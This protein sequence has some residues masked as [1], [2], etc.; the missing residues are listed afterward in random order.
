MALGQPNNKNMDKMTPEQAAVWKD[1]YLDWPGAIPK[2]E[3]RRLF[4][5][6]KALREQLAEVE[7]DRDSWKATAEEASEK[8]VNKVLT[9]RHEMREKSLQE[10]LDHRTISLDQAQAMLAE[11]QQ[12]IANL[13]RQRSDTCTSE[14]ALHE[15]KG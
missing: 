7:R 5:S 11:A 12:K 10:Q 2:I 9:Q 4:D 1:R 13:E 8:N 6:Y 3:V 15:R 14:E